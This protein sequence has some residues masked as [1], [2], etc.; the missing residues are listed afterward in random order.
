MK[1]AVCTLKT[2]YMKLKHHLGVINH[3]SLVEFQLI[4]EAARCW[5]S[6]NV[7]W[8]VIGGVN[9]YYVRFQLIRWSVCLVKKIHN[10][11]SIDMLTTYTKGCLS[12]SKTK[13]ESGPGYTGPAKQNTKLTQNKHRKTLNVCK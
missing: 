3:G 5:W 4:S 11:L 9:T 7:L 10:M 1:P 13:N 2:F 12:T 6:E 8:P